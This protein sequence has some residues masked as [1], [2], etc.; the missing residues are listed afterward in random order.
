VGL[1]TVAPAI[2]RAVHDVDPELPAMKFATIDAI[3]DASMANRRF[4]TVATAAFAAVAL[5]LTV[6][7]LLVV[8]SR[9]VI[10]RRRELAIRSALGA[11]FAR[12][13][14]AATSPAIAA[15]G[16]GVVVGIGAAFAASRTLEQFL[17]QVAP[18]APSI[19][20][21]VG[22]LVIGVAFVAALVPLRSLAKL[23]L[24]SVLNAE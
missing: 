8:V 1:E 3:L 7:G 2:R 23:S 22:G 14:G 5:T 9:V 24:V 21:G 10:E 15:I 4:Y 19:Y 18:R 11:T 16:A 12:V 6:V 17:F 13:A 20:A